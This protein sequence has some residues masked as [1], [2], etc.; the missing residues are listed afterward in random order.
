MVSEWESS[1]CLKEEVTYGSAVSI[2]HYFAN[3]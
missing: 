1:D 2:G 3:P